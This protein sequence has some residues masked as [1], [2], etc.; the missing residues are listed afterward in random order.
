MVYCVPGANFMK[1]IRDIQ[2]RRDIGSN[3]PVWDC[4]TYSVAVAIPDK[5]FSN[6]FAFKA[7]RLCDRGK[8][9]KSE[10][11]L[12]HEYLILVVHGYMYRLGKI[13]AKTEMCDSMAEYCCVL[14]HPLPL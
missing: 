7:A 8:N 5:H 3:R 1:Y 11:F 6:L 14:W 9:M 12:F 4:F 10:A 13:C 2:H